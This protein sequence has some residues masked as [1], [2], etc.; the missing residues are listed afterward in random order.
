MLVSIVTPL[1]L[2]LQNDWSTRK[3]GGSTHSSSRQA[4][5]EVTGEPTQN[6]K[7]NFQNKIQI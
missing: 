6:G 5:P 2:P 3:C 1:L 7:S 4:G